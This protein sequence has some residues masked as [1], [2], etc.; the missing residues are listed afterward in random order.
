MEKSRATYQKTEDPTMDT[1]RKG[2]NRER[3]GDSD[4][5]VLS[6]PQSEL[7]AMLK[8]A[9]FHIQREDSIELFFSGNLHFDTL[10]RPLFGPYADV[11]I[12]GAP[13]ESFVGYA[14]KYGAQILDA[15]LCAG[16]HTLITETADPD[17]NPSGDEFTEQATYHEWLNSEFNNREHPETGITCQGCHV[18]LLDDDIGVVLS[19]N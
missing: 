7:A 4:K 14:P 17:G 18:P 6:I 1:G 12:F 11:D 19:A 15:G 2:M 16:C 3:P 9:G 10:N 8:K 5:Y 13:M